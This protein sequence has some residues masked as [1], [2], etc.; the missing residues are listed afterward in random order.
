M[1]DS[2]SV[3]FLSVVHR[4]PL[5]FDFVDYKSK[6]G[7]SISANVSILQALEIWHLLELINKYRKTILI[8]LSST[9]VKHFGKSS[10]RFT[11]QMVG[12]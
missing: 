7:N 10:R 3:K 1:Q 11:F 12:V 5:H 4:P 9:Q 2:N 8:S 6:S